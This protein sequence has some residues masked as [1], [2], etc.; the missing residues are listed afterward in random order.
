MTIRGK[1]KNL[2]IQEARTIDLDYTPLENVLEYLTDKAEGLTDV[3]LSIE[4]DYQYGDHYIRSQLVGWRPATDV[5]IAEHRAA[6]A[7]ADKRVREIQ[8]Q[9]AA[10]LRKERPDL[11]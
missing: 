7:E 5:E 3:R 9:Q 2:E 4:S 6:K 8:E 1:G 10:S 11:F